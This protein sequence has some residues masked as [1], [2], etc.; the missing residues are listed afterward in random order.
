MCVFCTRVCV[1]LTV[2]ELV[3]SADGVRVRGRCPD[4][5]TRAD[6]VGL[7]KQNGKLHSPVISIVSYNLMV[8]QAKNHS[9]VIC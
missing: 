6:H 4:L 5:Y 1:L 7:T 8:K 2:G 3:A 9:Y